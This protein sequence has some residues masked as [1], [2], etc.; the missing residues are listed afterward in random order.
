ML[1]RQSGLSD[2]LVGIIGII[3]Y[4]AVCVVMLVNG[5]HSDRRIERRWHAAIPC[6]LAAV[7]AVGLMAHPQSLPISVLL[8]TLFAMAPAALPPFWGIPTMPL[9]SSTA[10]PAVGFIN[11]VGSIAGFAGP[12]ALGYLSSRTGSF[13]VGMA[14]AA[15]AGIGAALILLSLPGAGFPAL[16][17]HPSAADSPSRLQ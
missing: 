17:P 14:A 6:P 11:A 16:A 4:A 10:A 3:P 7:G 9:G 15:T 5:W 12:F 2:V 8:F 13:T 1:K